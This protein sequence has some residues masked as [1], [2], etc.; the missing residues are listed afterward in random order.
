MIALTEGNL[1]LQQFNNISKEKL[2]G[3]YNTLPYESMPFAHTQP[4]SLAA[5]ATLFGLTPPPVQNCRV[6]ELGCASGG[7]IIPMAAR[8]PNARF[9][10]IDLALRHVEMGA[11]RIAGLGL[12]NIEIVQGDLANPDIVSGEFDYIICHGVYSWVPIEARRGI[13][14]IF[15]K[16]LAPNGIAYIS[17]NVL[18]GWHMRKVIRDIFQFHTEDIKAPRDRVARGRWLLGQLANV[19]SE[20]TPYGQLLR[21]EAKQLS[22]MPDSYILG[23]FLVDENAP[24]YF[25]EF[26][27]QA[28]QSGLAYLCDTDLQTT[29]IG[30]ANLELSKLLLAITGSDM[31][32]SEQYFDFF[33]GRQFRQSLLIKAGNTSN[34]KRN[35]DHKRIERLYFGTKLR[36]N[37][38]QSNVEELALRDPRGGPTITT[39]DLIVAKAIDHVG[40]SAPETKNLRQIL[41]YL[42]I[43]T[44]GD[45]QGVA[46]R[47]LTT[48]LRLV[49]SGLFN[50]SALPVKVGRASDDKPRAWL[51]ARN[52]A[53][54]GQPWTTNLCHA[55][56]K[57]DP[58]ANRLLPLLDGHHDSAS[59]V[60]LLAS[61]VGIE[62]FNLDAFI[63]GDALLKLAAKIDLALRQMEQFGLLEPIQF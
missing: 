17:Y 6:L 60:A 18:P 1:N 30:N 13:F 9:K 43:K 11:S 21:R 15:E 51:I 28:E 7:N 49:M 14:K 26:M 57:L 52:D 16:Q 25:H 54:S 23:E 56:I 42:E 61:Q 3:Q 37:S 22:N 36:L 59:L 35:D 10:G 50:I 58:V 38:D 33:H 39:N 2:G 31:Q 62:E 63:G 41:D 40:A 32:M 44:E 47:I 29:P 24:C 27:E 45:R 8:F 48:T 20:A 53:K 5:L 4:A 55:P 19:S 34:I 46:D 12:K